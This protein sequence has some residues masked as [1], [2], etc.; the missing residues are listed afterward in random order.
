MD[1]VKPLNL[2]GAAPVTHLSFYNKQI[3][4]KRMAVKVVPPHSN[5]QSTPKEVDTLGFRGWQNLGC[6][7][8]S[9]LVGTQTLFIFRL[10][11]AALC[12]NGRAE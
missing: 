7:F 11:M 12:Y 6:L 8:V 2:S 4:E 3:K 10:S 1:M 5:P 9:R